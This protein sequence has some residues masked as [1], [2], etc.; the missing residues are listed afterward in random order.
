MNK[1]VKVGV[2]ALLLAGLVAG[3][4]AANY[5]E[6]SITRGTICSIS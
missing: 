3:N 6:T 5:F 4:W 1:K 2:A